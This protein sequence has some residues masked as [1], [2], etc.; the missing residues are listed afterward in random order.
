MDDLKLSDVMVGL[1]EPNIQV[2]NTIKAALNSRGFR[3]IRDVNTVPALRDALAGAFLD[4]LIVDVHLGCSTA[5]QVTGLIRALRHHEFGS[6]PFLPIIAITGDPEQ[7]VINQVIDAGADHVM[8]KPL[9]ISQLE[10]RIRA[11]AKA[12]KPFVVT[13]DYIGPDRRGASRP[14]AAGIPVLEVPNVLKEKT[15]GKHDPARLQ[16]AISTIAARVNT[17]KMERHAQRLTELAQDV[18]AAFATYS[19][20]DQTWAGL[21]SMIRVA[22]DIQR[23]TSGTRYEPVAELCETLA[24][25][26]RRIRDGRNGRRHREANLMPELARGI[27]LAFQLDPSQKQVVDT[28]AETVQ[29]AQRKMRELDR[30]AS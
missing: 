19:V 12:R 7:S 30:A 25:V 28:I 29:T 6:N 23:R 13:S 9:S 14:A 3:E 17:H 1:G 21:D 5:E 10:T 27:S 2:R 22:E 20:D 16:Q 18:N 4:L 26:A 11:L 15:T 24:M 8:A